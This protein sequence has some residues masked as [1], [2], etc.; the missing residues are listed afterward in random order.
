MKTELTNRIEKALLSYY[1]SKIG[2]IRLNKRRGRSLAY[3]VPCVCGT[4]KGGLVDCV[5]ID[6]YFGDLAEKH[7]CR[8]FNWIKESKLATDELYDCRKGYK[9][10]FEV[11]YYCDY[12]TCIWNMSSKLGTEK[13][14]ITCYEIKVSKADFRSKNGHNF[15]G[16]CNYYVM[17]R[18][19]YNDVKDEIPLEIGA[20]VYKNGNLRREK[21]CCFTELT[22]EAEKWLI[23]NVLKKNQIR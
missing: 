7:I 23:L 6:E 15:I 10:P 8:V 12:Q 16:H 20:I 21:E 22:S 14:L 19:L 18:E 4:T 9:D 1:P 3:E 11:P 17:P 13:I 2:G 5:R